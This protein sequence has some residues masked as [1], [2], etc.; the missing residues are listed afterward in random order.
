[1][2]TPQHLHRTRILMARS[3]EM[4]YT[5]SI[6]AKWNEYDI[7]PGVL[8]KC[9]FLANLGSRSAD[10]CMPSGAYVKPLTSIHFLLSSCLHLQCVT[11]IE[12]HLALSFSSAA[13]HFEPGRLFYIKEMLAWACTVHILLRKYTSIYGQW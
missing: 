10:S 5:N 11:T 9:S 1:M 8:S 4:T 2:A 7:R 12:G 13:C 3:G 6:R